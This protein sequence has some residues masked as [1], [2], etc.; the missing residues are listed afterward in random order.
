MSNKGF[1]GV[2]AEG[3]FPSPCPSSFA[4]V[5]FKKL[6][7]GVVVASLKLPKIEGVE[8]EV[9]EEEE[10]KEPKM[11]GLEASFSLF[12]LS[13]SFVFSVSVGFSVVF[14]DSFEVADFSVS[15]SPSTCCRFATDSPLFKLLSL[16]STT[17]VSKGLFLP[18]TV[19]ERRRQK[20][21]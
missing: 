8:E 11:R 10:A 14:V 2:E 3:L 5:G 21:R 1:A 18:S 17:A 7:R 9:V 15:P 13:A 20:S 19:V 12:S 4:T 16:A 6:K